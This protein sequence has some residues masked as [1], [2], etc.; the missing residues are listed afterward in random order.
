MIL[1]V[2]AALSLALGL[3]TFL[4]YLGLVGKAPWSPP[5]MRHL[6]A[7]KDR[8][9]APERYEALG[10]ADFTALPHAVTLAERARLERRGVSFDGWVQR[11]LTAPD[12]DTHFELAPKPLAPGDPD[13][14]YVTAE[15]S[16][17]WWVGSARW[18]YE[19]LVA[20]L[21]PNRGG[22]TAWDGGPR[23]ARVS[24]WLMHDFQHDVIPSSWSLLHGAPRLTGWEIHPVTRIELWSDS[25]GRFVDVPR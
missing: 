15:V 5:A 24:G 6:R 9:S 17:Q 2:C 25:L 12:G 19:S 7:M 23:R 18:S 1:R 10:A 4:L 21:H 8:A 11:M 3:A 22:A 13:T 16:T 14:C 20:L